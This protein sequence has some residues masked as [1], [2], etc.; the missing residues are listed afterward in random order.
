MSAGV[1]YEE[2]RMHALKD[3]FGIATME[4]LLILRQKPCHRDM[5]IFA[6]FEN[7]SLSLPPC[8]TRARS[9]LFVALISSY[10]QGVQYLPSLL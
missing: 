6:T 8:A 7:K 9:I 3:L 4:L 5:K 10:A 1:T 2:S